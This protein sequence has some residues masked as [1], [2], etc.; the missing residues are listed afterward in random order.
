MSER[1]RKIQVLL[2]TQDDSNCCNFFFFEI[3]LIRIQID[4]NIFMV[5]QIIIELQL[6][7]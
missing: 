2:C 4:S 5:L 3:S 1:Y 6:L 7:I